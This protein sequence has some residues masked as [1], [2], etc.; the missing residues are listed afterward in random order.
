MRTALTAAL[1]AAFCIAG[2]AGPAAADPPLTH[3]KATFDET[4]VQ[5][6]D[7][8]D[9]PCVS[10]AGTVTEDRSYDLNITSHLAGPN[11]GQVHV[12]GKI[13]GLI[14]V[15]PD[16]PTAGPTYRGTYVEHLNFTGFATD[17]GDIPIRS[18]YHLNTRLTGSDGSHLNLH[19]S[20]GIVIGPDGQT[21]ASR[22]RLQC[23]GPR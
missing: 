9:G 1:A 22:N 21:R 17:E 4:S 2:F 13:N 6:F 15:A 18:A 14:A 10:Y 20:G 5:R 8:G 12:V 23:I 3:Q 11:A 7:P 16:Q 19:L